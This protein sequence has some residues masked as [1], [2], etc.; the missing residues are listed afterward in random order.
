MGGR[1]EQSGGCVAG[2]RLA[3]VDEVDGLEAL[4]CRALEENLPSSLGA[5]AALDDAELQAL[6]YAEVPQRGERNGAKGVDAKA[7][8]V[9]GD[10][11]ERDGQWVLRERRQAQQCFKIPTNSSRFSAVVL[12]S[13][14][15][16]NHTRSITKFSS[17]VVDLDSAPICDLFQKSQ[18]GGLKI[19]QPRLIGSSTNIYNSDSLNAANCHC[20]CFKMELVKPCVVPTFP[21]RVAV[22]KR[23]RKRL[24]PLNV[25]VEDGVDI[26]SSL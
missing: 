23:C 2:V 1:T 8:L 18:E 7:G 21:D 15:A 4:D 12:N 24:H 10:A 16:D 14:C 13:R 11:L 5:R 6:L 17:C 22:T 19:L 9:V 20:R 3:F 26:Q 25:G